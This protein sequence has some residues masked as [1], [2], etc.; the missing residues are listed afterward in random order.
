MDRRVDLIEGWEGETY[1]TSTLTD[2]FQSVVDLE[3]RERDEKRGG[4]EGQRLGG[5]RWSSKAARRSR[6]KQVK[7]WILTWNLNIRKDD[8]KRRK[9]KQEW[10]SMP[11][12]VDV[13]GMQPI[14]D[15]A[16]SMS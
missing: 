14:R 3:E 13:S 5:S 16:W 10:V 15:A 7:E 9:R 6:Q 12:A 4:D 8:H 1:S 11:I 2:S